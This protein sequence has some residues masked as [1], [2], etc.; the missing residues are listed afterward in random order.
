MASLGFVLTP[1]PDPRSAR[2]LRSAHHQVWLAVVPC[3]AADITA[4][5]VAILPDARTTG[6]T[7]HSRPILAAVID[8]RR[9]R[10][11]VRTRIGGLYG[12]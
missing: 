4:A 9:L 8:A 1:V 12:P 3:V 5:P 2:L 6:F 11:W 10:G 7:V